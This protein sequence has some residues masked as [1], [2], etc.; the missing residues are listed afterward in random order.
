[1]LIFLPSSYPFTANDSY[2]FHSLLY[3]FVLS[4]HC[5]K[6][7]TLD[8]KVIIFMSLFITLENGLK[9]FFIVGFTS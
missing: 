3:I 4:S 8:N 6:T 1:V 2:F 9:V 7:I 5:K